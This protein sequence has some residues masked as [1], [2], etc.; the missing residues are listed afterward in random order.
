[1]L[2]VLFVFCSLQQPWPPEICLCSLVS[3]SSPN[4][5]S[6]NKRVAADSPPPKAVPRSASE[7]LSLAVP[8]RG[9][10]QLKVAGGQDRRVGRALSG[11]VRQRAEIP[12]PQAG[13]DWHAPC[14]MLTPG[15]AETLKLPSPTALSNSPQLLSSVTRCCCPAGATKQP[16]VVQGCSWRLVLALSSAAAERWVCREVFAFISLITEQSALRQ[17]ALPLCCS[18]LLE[19]NIKPRREKGCSAHGN[20]SRC[21]SL[22]NR[23]TASPAEELRGKKKQ[24]TQ[25]CSALGKILI[26]LFTLIQISQHSPLLAGTSAFLLPP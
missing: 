19:L 5:H 24:G 4:Q 18:R 16:R 3:V 23:A 1:M 13:S 11:W 22:Q 14:S 7:G 10:L 8:G 21:I 2:L 26:L 6:R 9:R 25:I 15:H 20:S 17:T 12:V